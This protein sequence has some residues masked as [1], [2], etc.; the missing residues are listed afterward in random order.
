MLARAGVPHPATA[1]VPRRRRPRSIVPPYVVKPRFGSWGRDVF[2]C[3]SDAELERLL[4]VAGGRPWFRAL[5][6]VVQELV[7]AGG[8]D[9]RL[10]VAGGAVVGAIERVAQPGEWRTNV[11]LGASAAVSPRRRRRGSWPS[12]PPRRSVLDLAGVDLLI[13]LPRRVRRPRGQRRGRL[14]ARVRRRTATSS[15]PRSARSSRPRRPPGSPPS[16][17]V[18]RRQWRAGGAPRPRPA[19]GMGAEG[20]RGREDVQ[21]ED[22]DRGE[23][24]ARQREAGAALRRGGDD[25]RARDGDVR[26]R[27]PPRQDVPDRE[28]RDDD[29]REP[30]GVAGRRQPRLHAPS[31]SRARAAAGR[32]R[33]RRRRS[34]CAPSGCA[35]ASS[36]APALD[37]VVRDRARTNR[38]RQPARSSSAAERTSSPDGPSPEAA[39]RV[40]RLAP[41]RA[42]AERGGIEAEPV[43]RAPRS[44]AG[45]PRSRRRRSGRSGSPP[46]WQARGSPPSRR[47]GSANAS[48]SRRS[49]SGR[50]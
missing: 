8:R 50:G 30:V 31:G 34:G 33:A 18:P 44:R 41:V 7:G 13:G 19:R 16:R 25:L 37:E 29:E 9:L 45:A 15:P 12:A 21:P 43:L 26:G 36:R 48:T 23:H 42:R 22:P 20:D 32:G 27:E 5:G 1:H 49:H 40:E 4:A 35:G 38:V 6:A 46:R 10:V 17:R 14:H 3:E 28:E 2:R 47:P 24:E 11:A 39:D